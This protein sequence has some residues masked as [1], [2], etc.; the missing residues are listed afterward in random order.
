MSN[1]AFTLSESEEASWQAMSSDTPAEEQVSVGGLEIGDADQ[2]D[3][4]ELSDGAEETPA[5][6]KERPKFV[7]HQALHEER[8]RRKALEKE[9]QTAREER[10]RF[11]ERLKVIQEMNRR[12]E[13]QPEQ[14]SVLDDPVAAL[15]RLTQEAEDAKRQTQEREQGQRAWQDFTSAYAAKVE[16]F[17]QIEPDFDDAYKFLSNHRFQE[18]IEAGYPPAQAQAQAQQDE[19]NI[20]WQAMQKGVN[21]GETLLKIAKHRGYAKKA[22]APAARTSEEQIDKIADAKARNGS[23]TGSGGGPGNDEMNADRLARMPQA[24]FDAWCNKHPSKAK[25]LMGG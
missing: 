12:P 23:F 16:E 6:E 2:T 13:P 8:E 14:K 22:V 7:P 19:A 25:R 24:E 9:V 5:K 11:D 18:L 3:E 1:P 10:A 15:E 17:K 4:I 20:V 21:P